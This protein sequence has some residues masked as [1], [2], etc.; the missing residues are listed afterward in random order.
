MGQDLIDYKVVIYFFETGDYE[1]VMMGEIT[2]NHNFHA[3]T[4][5]NA[6][7]ATDTHANNEI[8]F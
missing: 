1:V 3:S 5:Q 8:V 6:L 2:E 7:M 4:H